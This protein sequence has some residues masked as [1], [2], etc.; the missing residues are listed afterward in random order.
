M[1][2]PATTGQSFRLSTA[3]DIV[4]AIGH[5]TNIHYTNEPKGRGEY[6]TWSYFREYRADLDQNVMDFA[7]IIKPNGDVKWFEMGPGVPLR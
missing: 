4:R 2:E 7:Y 1:A 3:S 6:E 5:P